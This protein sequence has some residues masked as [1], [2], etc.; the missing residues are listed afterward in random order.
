VTVTKVT[1]II[2]PAQMDEVK[3]ALRAWGITGLTVSEVRG[4]GRQR[5]HPAAYRGAEYVVGFVPK[6]QIEVVV[7][8][9]LAPR[10]IDVITKAART[11]TIGDGK[12]FA[13]RVEESIRIRTG[14]RGDEAL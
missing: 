9:S 2:K 3:D 4:Y 8:S 10:L 13:T 14:E 1:A 5:G 12:I 11:G 6:I 7:P